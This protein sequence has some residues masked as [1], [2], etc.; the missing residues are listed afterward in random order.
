MLSN[1]KMFGFYQFLNANTSEHVKEM[2]N[3]GI[4]WVDQ[5][6]TRKLPRLSGIN[7]GLVAVILTPKGR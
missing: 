2:M 4:T 5:M 1:V 7:W 6:S 3:Q